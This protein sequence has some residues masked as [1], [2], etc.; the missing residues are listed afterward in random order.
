MK[1]NLPSLQELWQLIFKVQMVKVTNK[2]YLSLM[3]AK[4]AGC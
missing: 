4:Q 2:T 1:N 3:I